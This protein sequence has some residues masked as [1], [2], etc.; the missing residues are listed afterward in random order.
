MAGQGDTA[1]AM[2]QLSAFERA[3]AGSLTGTTPSA[4]AL[5]ATLFAQGQLELRSGLADTALYSLARFLRVG[6]DSA[7]A[8]HEQARAL[9]ALDRSD[10]ADSLYYLGAREIRDSLGWSWYRHQVHW[11]VRPGELKQFDA[12]PLDQ[13]EPWLRAFW[14]RRDAEDG[15]P[16]G[17]RLAEHFRRWEYALAQY[18]PERRF[19]PKGAGWSYLSPSTQAVADQLRDAAATEKSALERLGQPQNEADGQAP[20]WAPFQYPFR[21]QGSDDPTLDDRGA[22]YMRLGNPDARANY[23][24]IEQAYAASWRYVAADGS[25]LVFHFKDVPFDGVIAPTTLSV[26]P[27]GDLEEACKIDHR[28]C[29]AACRGSGPRGQQEGPGGGVLS[30]ASG[31]RDHQ[32]RW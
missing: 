32:Y 3:Q 24:G 26:F 7:L 8:R 27:A 15:R 14:G 31:A 29:R 16:A 12:L 21:E 17:S 25:D 23:P 10:I 9:F 13:L 30:G 18:A 4:A 5:P 22:I 19:S 28:V 1:G 6:G 20:A 2:R 11:V